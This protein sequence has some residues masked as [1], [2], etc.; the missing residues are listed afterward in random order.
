MITQ[1]VTTKSVCLEQS[2][3]LTGFESRCL[4]S[5]ACMRDLWWV[6]LLQIHTCTVYILI[7]EKCRC[8][9]RSVSGDHGMQASKCASEISTLALKP[10]TW[11][12]K[13]RVPVAPRNGPRSKNVRLHYGDN[14]YEKTKALTKG[15][16][17]LSKRQTKTHER[18]KNKRLPCLCFDSF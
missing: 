8:N 3:V 2:S 13:Q 1:V 18:D 7:G 12:R 5:A 14:G 9:T 4:P 10:I 6:Y 16:T 15:Q 17:R 11:R